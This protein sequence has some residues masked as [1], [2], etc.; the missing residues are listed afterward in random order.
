MQ[1]VAAA[2]PIRAMRAWIPVLPCTLLVAALGASAGPARADVPTTD[3]NDTPDT[4]QG[5]LSMGVTY[6]GA[7]DSDQD[8]DWFTFAVG[9]G[10]Q[11]VVVSVSQP[12][13]GTCALPGDGAFAEL[14]G[15]SADDSPSL[16]DVSGAGTGA[17]QQIT[18]TLAG[19]ATYYVD[20][21]TDCDPGAPWAL[22][23]D[24]AGAAAAPSGGSAEPGSGAPSGT[25]PGVAPGAARTPAQKAK[26]CRRAKR[27]QTRWTATVAATRRD[28]RRARSPVTRRLAR[29]LLALQRS[30][31]EHVRARAKAAC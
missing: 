27:S 22:R 7:T 16:A 18:S 29:H 28:L 2:A 17:P 20:V 24:T 6:T 5:P 19:P 9:P 3:A 21:G 8:D 25:A 13:R 31:L 10:T 12:A 23:I 30:T 1:P 26:A 15:P 14:Y 4:A 11:R